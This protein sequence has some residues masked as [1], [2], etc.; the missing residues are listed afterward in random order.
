MSAPRLII[1]FTH[2]IIYPAQPVE[3]VLNLKCGETIALMSMALVKR[4]IKT[5]LI[6]LR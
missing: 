4:I 1:T 2:N 3:Q 5:N 6:K